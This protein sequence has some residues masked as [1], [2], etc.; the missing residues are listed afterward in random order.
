MTA[1]E[2]SVIVPV[3]RAASV[4][5]NTRG[6]VMAPRSVM[7]RSFGS[8]PLQGSGARLQPDKFQMKKSA[9]TATDCGGSLG[10]GNQP[11]FHLPRAHR[12]FLGIAQPLGVAFQIRRG[13]G[14]QILLHVLAGLHQAEQM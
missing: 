1:P 11:Q 4:C 8:M 10:R 9:W 6:R 7:R 12:G 2:A 14:D 3:M 13:H 5:E